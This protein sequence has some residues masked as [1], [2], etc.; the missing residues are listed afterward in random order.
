MDGGARDGGGGAL[1]AHETHPAGYP[2]DVIQGSWTGPQFDLVRDDDK[3]GRV[4]VEGW[5]TL[6][7]A[8]ELF[9][10]AGQD[11][12]TMKERALRS[13][14]RAVPL[15]I[16]ASVSIENDLQMSS[17]YHVLGVLPGSDRAGGCVR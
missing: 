3:M 1:S 12:G 15:G 5:L 2:W 17:A 7:A 9:T 16:T 8:E 10:L 6:E 4:A 11:Y 14:F 13:N